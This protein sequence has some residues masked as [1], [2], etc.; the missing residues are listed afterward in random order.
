MGY[1]IWDRIKGGPAKN[2]RYQS[3]GKA[4]GVCNLMN[5]RSSESD[6]F[7]VKEL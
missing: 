5:A 7:Y 4:Q 3:R 2:T 1:S 6:R